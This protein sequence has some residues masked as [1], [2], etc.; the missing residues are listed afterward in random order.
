M[1][2]AFGSFGAANRRACR[3]DASARCA[4]PLG[5]RLL[6]PMDRHRPANLSAAGAEI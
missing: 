3:R 1:T 2:A 6:F 4:G 5:A